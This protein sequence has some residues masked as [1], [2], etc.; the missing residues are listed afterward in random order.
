MIVSNELESM[1]KGTVKAYC[2]EIC[3]EVKV[4]LYQA[5]EA[6]RVVRRQGSLIFL[7]NHLMDDGE[8]V[9]LK[10]RPPF[11]PRKIPGNH[12]C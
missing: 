2:P 11:T 4:S 8:I 10:R 6:H 5:V 9:S 3:L 12:F 1:L 7:N